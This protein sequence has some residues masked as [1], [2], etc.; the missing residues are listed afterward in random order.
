MI[1]NA[2]LRYKEFHLLC[3]L[4]IEAFA[5]LLKNLSVTVTAAREKNKMV[6]FLRSRIKNNINLRLSWQNGSWW[7]KT[8]QWSQRFLDRETSPI[9]DFFFPVSRR[10]AMAK[11]CTPSAFLRELGTRVCYYCTYIPNFFFLWRGVFSSR[12][13]GEFFPT[14]FQQFL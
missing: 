8:P 1:K 10:R 13:Q 5:V 4:W 6:C 3:H 12:I 9:S 14:A 7:K 11:N 2:P